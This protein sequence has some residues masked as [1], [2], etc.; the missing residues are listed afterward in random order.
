M[1]VLHI[2]CHCQMCTHPYKGLPLPPPPPPACVQGPPPPLQGTSPPPPPPPQVVY[3][4]PS[5]SQWCFDVQWCPRN[6]GLI[7][8]SSFDGHI[9]VYSLL[10]GA[11]GEGESKEVSGE[12]RQEEGRW[13]GTE[14][15]GIEHGWVG[16]EV[17][18]A[19]V[20]WRNCFCCYVCSSFHCIV[21]AVYVTSFIPLSIVLTPLPAY[22][23]SRKLQ[24]IPMTHLVA[25]E[26]SQY[27]DK[28]SHSRSHPSG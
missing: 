23:R 19:K 3:E 12:G 22:S 24:W 13:V 10:G 1:S 20:R 27:R 5:T 26:S 18:T 25:L 14:G 2:L 15:E 28:R 17:C 4:V 6:P 7:S 9:S 8:T 16:R 11:G 21:A